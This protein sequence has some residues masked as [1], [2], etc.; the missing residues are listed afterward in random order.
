MQG[1]VNDLISLQAL[2]ALERREQATSSARCFDVVVSVLRLNFA[3]ARL[4]QFVNGS[5]GAVSSIDARRTPAAPQ[6][7][8]RA[9][10]CC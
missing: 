2:P 9:L 4:K 5:P 1:S 3:Y 10:D 8:G 7:I 6:E